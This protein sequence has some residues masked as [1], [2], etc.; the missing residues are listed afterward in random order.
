[1]SAVSNCIQVE[2]HQGVIIQL[3]DV[4]Y[5]SR[6]RPALKERHQHSILRGSHFICAQSRSLNVVVTCSR[7]P[8][9]NEQLL[10]V[11]HLGANCY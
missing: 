3:C 4:I 11:C 8:P 2:K 7:P 9:V 5:N 1:M 10:C 6:K